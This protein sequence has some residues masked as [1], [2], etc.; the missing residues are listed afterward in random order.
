MMRCIAAGAALCCAAFAAEFAVA[1]NA[2]SG[3][4]PKN[5]VK[6]VVARSVVA[7]NETFDVKFMTEANQVADPNWSSLNKDFHIRS[8]SKRFHKSVVNGVARAVHEWN[9]QL[10][11]KRGGKLQ[12]PPLQ[13]GAVRSKAT[14]IQVKPPPQVKARQSTEDFFIEV[15]A[16]PENPYVQAQ[17]LFTLKVFMLYD[18]RG[19][20]TPPQSASNALVEGLGEARRYRAKRGSRNYQVYE[21]EYLIYPQNSGNIPIKPVGLTGTYVKGG[22]RFSLNKKSRKL[23]L[24]VRQVPASFTGKFWL[25]AE[26]FK[27]KE[28][29]SA[30]LSSWRAGEPITRTLNLEVS[31]LL[32][33]Q[34]PE[35]ELSPG[36]DFRFYTESADFKNEKRKKTIVGKRQQSAV[37]IP[38]Q[39]GTYTLPAVKVPWWNTRSDR[40]EFVEL[41]AREVVIKEAAFSALTVDETP[42]AAAAAAGDA[43]QTAA[44]EVG[45]KVNNL[46]FWVSV[47]LLLA[48]LITI[49]MMWRGAG[50]HRLL[51]AALRHRE[52]LRERRSAVRQACQN[53]DAAAARDALMQW[54]HVIWPDDTPTSL[55]QIGERYRNLG[56]AVVEQQILKLERALYT[57][58]NVW[59][60]NLL[61]DAF[62]S[63]KIENADTKQHRRDE[64]EPLHKL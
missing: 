20:V 4:L 17:V 48:W 37:L 21:R 42:R 40:L 60:G 11:P 13:F 50:V 5:E 52:T 2:A 28:G 38:A 6:V 30:D 57:R 43:E 15:S 49:A 1:Q 46:W 32:A 63:Q 24:K 36:D 64:L 23:T 7:Q 34:I 35:V 59:Q 9:V 51:R 10:Q 27:I 3:A 56:G 39:A 62:D 53:N 54:A 33:K 22:R 26:S 29:W 58:D 55:G 61:W 14:P 45:I 31:G 44:L 8:K 16:Q 47:I 18:L 19:N 41:P 25:P 12:I